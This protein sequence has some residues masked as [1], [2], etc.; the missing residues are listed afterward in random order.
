M[1]I[2]FTVVNYRSFREPA[3]L[4]MVAANLRSRDEQ[5][6]QDNVLH[7]PGQPPLLA[8]AAIFGRNASGKSNLVRALRFMR[9]FVLESFSSTE[10][11]GAIAIEPFRLST[12]TTDKPSHF[13]IVVVADGVRYRYGFEATAERVTAE[14]LYAVPKTTE[15]LLFQRD[16]DA[17]KIGRSFKEGR[18]RAQ[19]TR[20]NAL[21]L[22]VVAQTNGPTAKKL[23]T[24]FRKLGIASGVA[25][26]GMRAYTMDRLIRERDGN[27]IAQIIT[28]G[29]TGIEGI[30]IEAGRRNEAPNLPAGLPEEVRTALTTLLSHEEAQQFAVNTQHTVYDA[31]GNAVAQIEFDLD[32]QESEGTR[33]LFALAGPLASAIGDGRV[34]VIDEVDARFHPLLTQQLLRAFNDPITNPKHA[35][36]IVVSHDT[37]LLNNRMLRRD[38]IWFVEK[39]SRGA[40]TLYSLAEF[41]GVRNDKD[42][43]AGY[44]EG[45][46]GAI[47]HVA[48]LTTALRESQATYGTQEDE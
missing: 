1:L 36:L 39:D 29:D 47:P 6:D 2:E 12:E 7:V 33:K 30:R 26:R 9:K 34:L 44:L 25:D 14:W 18:D 23:V 42:Y 27:T 24:W 20:P 16:L 22:T 3:L 21:F 5:L 8:T 43:E 41:K 4:S 40:S 37:D 38:Q 13:E 15:A 17:I 10:E 48:G 46:Y 35:Q 32:D 28:A 31:A 19:F 11:T 45:R